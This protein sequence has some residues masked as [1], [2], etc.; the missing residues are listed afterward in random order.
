VKIFPAMPVSCA[1]ELGRIRMPKAD[2]PW[3]IFD[4]NNQQRRFIHALT[5]GNTNE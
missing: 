4:Q 5:I 1:V 2:P 3:T